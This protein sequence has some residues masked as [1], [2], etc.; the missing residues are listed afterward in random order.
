MQDV[1]GN[2]LCDMIEEQLLIYQ[3]K[4]GKEAAY[5]LLY[6]KHYAVLCHLAREWVGDDYTAESLVGDV[7]FHLWEI[8]ESLEIRVSLRSYLLQAVRNRCLDYLASRRER[9]EIA[10]SALEGEGDGKQPLTERYIQ[11][12]DYPLGRLL[13]RELEQEIRRSIAALPAECRQVFLKSR[14]E[15]KKYEKIAAEL[16]ISVNTVKYHIKNALVRL[17]DRLG[18]YLACLLAVFLV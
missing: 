10:F 4:Q 14:F 7:I 2:R 1:I 12:D 8:R 16:G 18:K 5:K 11:L 9:T 3:L 13:E 17:H 15:R 6:E